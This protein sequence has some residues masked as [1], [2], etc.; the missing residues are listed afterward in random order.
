MGWTEKGGGVNCGWEGALGRTEEAEEE[1]VGVRAGAGAGPGPE[2]G[3]KP[4]PEQGQKNLP[5]PPP[6]IRNRGDKK[7]STQKPRE[8]YKINIKI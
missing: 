7:S 2:S 8:N 5:P 1:G 4:G 3:P 6:V